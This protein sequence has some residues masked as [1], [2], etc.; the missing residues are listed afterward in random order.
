MLKDGLSFAAIICAIIVD[1]NIE[2]D[3]TLESSLPVFP[4]SVTLSVNM[5]SPYTL[6]QADTEATIMQNL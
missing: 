2:F 1:V 3:N 6:N 4:K 5:S